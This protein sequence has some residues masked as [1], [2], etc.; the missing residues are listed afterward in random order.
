[1]LEQIAAGMPLLAGKMNKVLQKSW[2]FWSNP[3]NPGKKKL[4]SV[5]IF[6]VG[7][8]GSILWHSHVI[9]PPKQ[10][11]DC[12]FFLFDLSVRDPSLDRPHCNLGTIGHIDHG[13]TTLTA[14]ITKVMQEQGRGK[15]VKYD[16]IDNAPEEKARGITI[17]AIHV[18]YSTESRHYSHTDC[19]GHIGKCSKSSK[20][21]NVYILYHI[22]SVNRMLQ[23]QVASKR[24]TIE[25]MYFLNFH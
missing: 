8:G 20:E 1:M 16:E 9:T 2:N 23:C 18:E 14:A 24:V 5:S 6:L 10:K 7:G 12:I 11:F 13:K 4:P 25:H 22:N 3:E 17:N 21:Y 15:F 19:P